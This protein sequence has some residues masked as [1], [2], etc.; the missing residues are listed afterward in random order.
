MKLAK[1]RPAVR[2][3][4]MAPHEVDEFVPRPRHV[5]RF[6]IGERS[7]GGEFMFHRHPADS[8]E[9]ARV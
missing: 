8:D 7:R 1:R 3:V 4:G 2:I 9:A 5:A 6:L